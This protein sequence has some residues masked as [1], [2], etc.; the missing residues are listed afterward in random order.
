M[1]KEDPEAGLS[2]P[3]SPATAGATKSSEYDSLVRGGP[4]QAERATAHNF[5]RVREISFF[6]SKNAPIKAFQFIYTLQILRVALV[7]VSVLLVALGLALLVA[8]SRKDNKPKGNQINTISH[9]I[10]DK[11]VLVPLILISLDGFR[12]DYMTR[13]KTPNLQTLANKGVKAQCM[14]RFFMPYHKKKTPNRNAGMQPQFPSKTFPNHYTIGN[15]ILSYIYYSHI[16]SH[17]I[18]SRIPWYWYEKYVLRFYYK[19]PNLL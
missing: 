19:I 5:N 9:Y 8:V 13:E 1:L 3:A 12:W 18:V 15:Q 16:C 11:T 10:D 6:F 2:I 4:S 7:V 14:L 17:W